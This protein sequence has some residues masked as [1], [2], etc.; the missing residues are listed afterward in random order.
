MTATI[1][2]VGW[3]HV[4]ERRLLCARSEGREVFYV[5]GGKPEPG[6][7]AAAALLR[8]I[9][10]ELGVALDPDSIALAGRFAAPADGK[11]GATVEVD[12][13]TATHAGKPEPSGEIAELRFL[14][15]DG[16]GVPVSAVTRLILDE[17]GT[18]DVID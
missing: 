8:E 10:E 11:P 13:F 14:R 1:R 3:L 2:K 15:R 18:R 12:A 17:L 9:R 4:A 6:E 5:P 16:D 7:D